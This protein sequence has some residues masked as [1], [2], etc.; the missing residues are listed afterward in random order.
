MVPICSGSGA[1]IL[2]SSGAMATVP[3]S[4]ADLSNGLYGIIVRNSIIMLTR[5]HD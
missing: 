4:M 2:S 1:A 5:L 3:G